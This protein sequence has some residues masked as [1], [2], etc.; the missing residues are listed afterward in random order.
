VHGQKQLG[1]FGDVAQVLHQRSARLACLQVLFVLAPAAAF[2]YV[3]QYFLKLLAIHFFSSS[4][5]LL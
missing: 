3:R 4:P 2:N 5:N 1:L